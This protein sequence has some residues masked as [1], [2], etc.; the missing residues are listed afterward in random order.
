MKQVLKTALTV[1][2]AGRSGFALFPL[3]VLF[4]SVHDSQKI[5]ESIIKAAGSVLTYWQN[6]G[7]S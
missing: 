6:A 4:S 7:H 1:D 3:F 2:I 5:V